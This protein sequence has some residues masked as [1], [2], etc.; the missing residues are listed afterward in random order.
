MGKIE[1]SWYSRW[2]EKVKG[3]GI[4]KYLK[5]DW[6]KGRWQRVARFKLGNEMRKGIYWEEEEKRAC[7]LCEGKGETWEHVWEKCRE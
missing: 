7:R 5:K 6:G 2:Y 4:P 1:D 3:K